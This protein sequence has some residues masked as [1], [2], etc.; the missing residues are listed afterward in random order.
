M[1]CR[2]L[3]WPTLCTVPERLTTQWPTLYHYNITLPAYW[4]KSAGN[5]ELLME[6]PLLPFNPN[7]P[8]Q[9]ANITPP[10]A[11]QTTRTL[12]CDQRLDGTGSGAGLKKNLP[13]M[14]SCA[15]G[16]PMCCWCPCSSTTWT[17]MSPD[18]RQWYHSEAWI[19]VTK[20]RKH[21]FTKN[22]WSALLRTRGENV[23][24][25][26]DFLTLLAEVRDSPVKTK[27]F[28]SSLISSGT[29]GKLNLCL[30]C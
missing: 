27:R 8:Q 11:T 30:I 12:E 9:A 10:S 1:T 7:L 5:R 21:S 16:G 17:T 22:S 24:W 3:F 14:V 6:T 2:V 13:L 19:S 28:Q 18:L 25:R 26:T 23:F 20:A 29:W 15:G 4:I